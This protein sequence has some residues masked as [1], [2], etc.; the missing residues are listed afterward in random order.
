MEGNSVF[1]FAALLAIWIVLA[2]YLMFL[3]GRVTSL[4]REVQSLER[5]SRAADGDEGL[6]V[7]AGDETAADK[8][9]TKCFLHATKH[10]SSWAQS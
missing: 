8:T 1:I 7:K 9:D 3:S 4:S 2:L 6:D 5:R 10:A